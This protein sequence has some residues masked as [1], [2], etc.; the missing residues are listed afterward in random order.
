M[1]KSIK[2][3]TEKAQRLAQ[4]MGVNVLSTTKEELLTRVKE[5]ITHNVK[6][7]ILTPNSE[8]V[9]MAQSNKELK[10]ALNTCDF[11]IPDT[12]GLKYAYKFLYGK[13]LNIIPGRKLFL[14]LINLASREGWRVFLLGGLDNEA[15]LCANRLI[16][17]YPNILISSSGGPQVSVNLS[18]DI[19]DKI[20]K[21]KPHLLFV[22][23]GNPKQEIWVM[24][25][26]KNLNAKCTMAVGGTFRYI[27]GLSI[28]PPK[29]M[30]QVG[31][32]WLWRLITEPHRIG[33]ILNAV[34]VFPLKVF[35][36]KFNPQ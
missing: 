11:P 3:N 2:N 19:V 35:W 23:F 14:D 24:K 33:R 15:E 22:A 21:F 32:E 9:L 17:L 6:F 30:E 10:D 27:A 28:L 36:S 5:K 12:V 25:N 20:N 7:S 34:I 13:N 31:L 26:A 29:W 18:K 1:I 16:S 4:I 8:L